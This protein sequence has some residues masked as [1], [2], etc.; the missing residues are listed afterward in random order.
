MSRDSDKFA[1]AEVVNGWIYR[2]TGQWDKLSTLF[3]EEATIEVTW[4]EGSAQA[5]IEASRTM[6]AST[7]S[8]KHL[9]GM[10]LIAFNDD[11]AVAETNATIVG[12]NESIAL[13]STTHCRL[14]DCL[15]KQGGEWKI[16]DRQVV[17]DSSAFDFPKGAVAIDPQ[18]ID[19]F[20]M[21]YASL[22]YIL[23]SGGYEIKRR[24]ATRNSPEERTIRQK[25]EAWLQHR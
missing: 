5:F 6:A 12:M 18:I 11:K 4:F 24:F 1:I 3:T 8:S 22:G 14:I 10:P 23:H 2:D 15:I 20:P 19:R 16:V 25:A 13:G 9:I 17:Y 21:A 7:L